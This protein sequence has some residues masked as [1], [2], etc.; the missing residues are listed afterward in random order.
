MTPV[1][2]VF[3]KL[4]IKEITVFTQYFLKQTVQVFGFFV[5]SF[6]IFSDITDQIT[7][8]QS[9]QTSLSK[10]WLSNDMIEVPRYVS[11]FLLLLLI[12]VKKK[13][14]FLFFFL[15]MFSSPN[16]FHIDIQKICP[17]F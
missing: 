6:H 9:F 7:N 12:S 15:L 3:M 5:S 1:P 17:F 13:P 11:C 2:H 10:N 8:R 14:H 4:R 16:C